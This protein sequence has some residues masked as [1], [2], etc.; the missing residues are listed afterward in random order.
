MFAATEA[1][2]PFEIEVTRER[3]RPIGFNTIGGMLEQEVA[4]VFYGSI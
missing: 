1:Y 4:D 2:L 3:I